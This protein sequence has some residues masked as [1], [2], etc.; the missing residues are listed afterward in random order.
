MTYA[1]SEVSSTTSPVN[2]GWTYVDADGW[3]RGYVIDMD[4]RL[5]AYQGTEPFSCHPLGSW[6]PDQLDLAKQ[7]VEDRVKELAP[8]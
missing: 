3:Q 4:V 6:Q 1:W 2:R 7:A 8:P 5:D